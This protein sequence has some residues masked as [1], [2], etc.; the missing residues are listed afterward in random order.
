MHAGPWL[1]SYRICDSFY[2]AV[3]MIF[4]EVA[5]RNDGVYENIFLWNFN[6]SVVTTQNKHSLFIYKYML[7]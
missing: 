6:I 5:N 3:K 7:L 2:E 4:V 1:D